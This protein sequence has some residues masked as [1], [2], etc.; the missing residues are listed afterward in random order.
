MAWVIVSIF[1]VLYFKNAL[2][3]RFIIIQLAIFFGEDSKNVSYDIPVINDLPVS[4]STTT[5]IL[6]LLIA[7]SLGAE[8]S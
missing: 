6:E 4:Y 2:N 5:L 3:H 7:Y 1:L 8:F